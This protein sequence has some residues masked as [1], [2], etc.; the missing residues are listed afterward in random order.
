MHATT[1]QLLS[2]YDAG[3]R[4]HT[5]TRTLKAG[6]LYFALKG[7]RFDGNAYAR[8]ALEAGAFRA[9]VDDVALR[10]EPGMVWVEDALGALQ[11]LARA[12]RRRFRGRVIGL[13]GSN[14]KTT[15][16]ELLHAVLNRRFRA[17][18]T[19]GN[20]NN[21]IG[22]PLTLLSMPVEA[23]FAIV[24]LGAN[25]VGEIQELCAIAEPDWGVITNIGLAH[26]EGF[27]G[28]EGVK[29]GKRELFQFI[30][31]QEAGTV[32][33][34]ASKP[35]LM[36]VSEGMHRILYGTREFPPF[37]EPVNNSGNA[38]NGFHFHADAARH[39]GPHSLHIDGMHNL[40]NALLAVT[41]GH[42]CGVPWEDALAAVGDYKP[43]NN[44]SQWALGARNRVLLDAYNANPSSMELALR[45]FAAAGHPSPLAILGDMGELGEYAA[46]EHKRMVQLGAELALE[47]WTVGPE[48]ERAGSQQ[49]GQ[50]FAGAEELM[51]YLAQHP[52]SGRTVLLKGSR[53]MQLEQALD[54]L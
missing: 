49:G 11:D 39:S 5:D 35:L 45:T 37:L 36:E 48:F 14:G 52:P 43:V 7:E 44:R 50:A 2:W 30:A 25:A 34:N 38:A 46:A 28:P 29:R 23:D 9:V 40:E 54:L 18:A 19:H 3:H 21:E 8:R 15:T 6:D 16:K 32:F 20:L 47:V 31:G 42:A 17:V 4:V 12:H 1:E 41:V 22:V 24:E 27:G 26:L 53:S 10:E 51:R 33:V 13:T